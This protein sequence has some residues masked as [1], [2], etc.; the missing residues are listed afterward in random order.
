VL[1]AAWLLPAE[2]LKAVAR[3]DFVGFGRFVPYVEALIGAGQKNFRPW[4]NSSSFTFAIEAGAGASSMITPTVAITAGYRFQH[5]SNAGIGERN[6]GYNYDG[7][8]AGVS[9]V[10]P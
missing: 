3:Y 4:D 6:R 9:I 8:A 1:I 5:L 7:G 2:G 10:F